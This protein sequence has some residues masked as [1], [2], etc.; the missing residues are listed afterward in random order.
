MLVL[1]GK[2]PGWLTVLGGIRFSKKSLFSISQGVP[3]MRTLLPLAGSAGGVID[4]I[5]HVWNDFLA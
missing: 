5:S 4:V 2:T 3:F 1:D